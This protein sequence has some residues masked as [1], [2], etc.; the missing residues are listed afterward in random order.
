MTELSKQYPEISIR[1][2]FIEYTDCH[3]VEI[4]PV[5]FHNEDKLFSISEAKLIFEFEARFFP[6]TVLF[7]TEDSLMSITKPALTW[8][9]F[10]PDSY[11]K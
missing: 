7:I 9:Q 6:E 5:S 8:N 4:S 10:R 2:Q 11:I 3:L 1:Y